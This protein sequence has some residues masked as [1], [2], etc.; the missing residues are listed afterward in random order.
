MAKSIGGFSHCLVNGNLVFH[1]HEVTWTIMG[2]IFILIFHYLFYKWEAKNLDLTL[3][4]SSLKKVGS[5]SD[6]HDGTSYLRIIVWVYSIWSHHVM[7]RARHIIVII[8]PGF[9]WKMVA[10]I[11]GLSYSMQW[12]RCMHF[13]VWACD[14]VWVP[15][16]NLVGLE[17]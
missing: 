6:C 10:L 5:D 3:C 1:M 13:V 14:K 11:M 7:G 12:W 15:S 16:W 9:L 2:N 8:K 4:S 17:S